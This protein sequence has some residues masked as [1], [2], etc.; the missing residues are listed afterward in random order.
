MPRAKRGAK[1]AAG[2]LDGAV[3]AIGG[4]M[5]MTRAKFKTHLEDHGA[6]V[7][8]TVTNKVTHLLC[9]YAELMKGTKKVTTAQAKGVPIVAESF[10]D[11]AIELGSIDAVAVD[12]H[13]V[14]DGAAQGAG[15]GAGAGTGAKRAVKK[16]AKKATAKAKPARKS[17]KKKRAA[18]DD[19]ASDD[20]AAAAP[21]QKRRRGAATKTAKKATATTKKRRKKDVVVVDEDDDVFSGAVFAITGSLSK[22]R[23]MFKADIEA[24]GGVLASSVTKKVNIVLS[25]AAYM[26]A[27]T[28]KIVAAK[29]RGVPIVSESFIDAACAAGSWKDVD[30]AKYAIDDGGDDDDDE[31]DDDV[32]DDSSSDEEKEDV[33]MVKMTKKGAV[34]NDTY[35]PANINSTAHVHEFRGVV[36]ACMLNQTNIKNNNNK[37]YVIQLLESDSGGTFWVWTRWGRVG[38]PGQ[39][40]LASYGS[41]RDAAVAFFKKKFHDKTKNNW[42]NRARFVK[43]TGK[44]Q[45]I[46]MNYEPDDEDESKSA[47]GKSKGKSKAKTVET[48]KSKLPKTL[49]ELVSLI[50]NVDMMKKAMVEIGFDAKK[51]PLGKLSQKTIKDGYAVL[52][53]IAAVLEG[54]SRDDLTELSGEFY[55]II[56]HD[57]GFRKMREFVI[58]DT[59]TLKKKIEMVESLADIALATKLL[60][61]GTLDVNPIDAHYRK[62][63]CGL[64]PL[65]EGSGELDMIRKYVNNTHAP[66]HSAYTLEVEGA[67]EIERESDD[68]RFRKISGGID[69]H[70]LLW[71]GSRLTNF[72]GILSQGLRI[73]P[74]EAPVTGYMFGKGVYF[75]NMVSK[76]ANYCFTNPTNNTGLL[77]LC[78]VALGEPRPLKKADYYANRLPAGTHSTHGMGRTGPDPAET[79]TM[80]DGVKV[81]LG[82][83]GPTNVSGTS[84]LYD[85]FIVYDVAQIRMRYLVRTKFHYKARGW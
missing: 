67:F 83:H 55:T 44:Y 77:L 84:L 2:P 81:P 59:Q 65:E 74:P 57:F 12:D 20:G 47:G 56:P 54:K 5:S 11:E 41:N 68:K 73:A 48:P 64:T 69:N 33:K 75:A 82:S 16:P 17:R 60:R 32:E 51:M 43:V 71:H 26:S 4:T 18:S 24:L 9:S 66:T 3:F 22:P 50:C 49:Q 30:V 85:E 29:A 21:P 70:M 36:Y 37:F 63:Q 38:V 1:K 45:L 76:S 27:A 35:L 80:S 28:S 15:A 78:E 40:A 53:R 72:V 31:D 23:K 58:R 19:E 79:I 62:L 7:A 8:S 61:S 42:E 52:T 39:N 34:P 10:V 14:S 6:T 13:E 46:E 25:T